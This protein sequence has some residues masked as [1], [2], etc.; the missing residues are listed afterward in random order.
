MTTLNLTA[1]QINW[2]FP[3]FGATVYGK[4]LMLHRHSRMPVPRNARKP[5]KRKIHSMNKRSLDRMVF[6]VSTSGIQF[7]SLL[8]LTYGQNYP[9]NG[10]RVKSDL[11]HFLLKMKRSFGSFSYFWFLEFQRRGAPHLHMVMTLPPPDECK[12]ELMATIWAD[13]TEDGNW[14]Y[15]EV[16]PPYKRREAGFGMSTKDSVFR[17]HRR[18]ETWSGLKKQDG[19]IRYALKYAAKQGQKLVPKSYR[20]VGRFWATS[21]DVRPPRGIEVPLNEDEVRRLLHA[22]GRNFDNFAVLPKLIF[23]P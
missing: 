8:T 11:N 17:Q 5:N 2:F 6:Y 13:I 18:K 14:Y 7:S 16:R 19:A 1:E 9:V 12:R 10:K 21:R 3:I 22:I 20:D 4:A 23:L 15:T